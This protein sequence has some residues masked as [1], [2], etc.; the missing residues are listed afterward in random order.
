MVLEVGVIVEDLSPP[1]PTSLPPTRNA[2]PFKTSQEI[3]IFEIG[4]V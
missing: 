2:S 4:T 3:F 1:P